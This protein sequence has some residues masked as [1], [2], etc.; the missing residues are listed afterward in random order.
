MG[1]VESNNKSSRKILKLLEFRA[2]MIDY[3]ENV[4]SV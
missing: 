3:K 1:G 4:S 2:E